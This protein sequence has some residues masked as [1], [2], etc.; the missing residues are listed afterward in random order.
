METHFD[1]YLF[2][3]LEAPTA[4]IVQILKDYYYYEYSLLIRCPWLVLG[5]VKDCLLTSPVAVVI[6]GSACVYV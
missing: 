1:A 3:Y 2:V 6:P 5:R 4:L